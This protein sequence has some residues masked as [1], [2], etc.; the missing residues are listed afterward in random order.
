M[1]LHAHLWADNGP[2]TILPKSSPPHI[3][4]IANVLRPN[5]RRGF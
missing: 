4:E 2:C 5:T 3:D 1:K